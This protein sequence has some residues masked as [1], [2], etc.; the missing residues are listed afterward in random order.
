[1]RAA[2]GVV[3]TSTI[4]PVGALARVEHQ[5]REIEPP[6]REPE[7]FERL[8]HLADRR[9]HARRLP[10]FGPRTTR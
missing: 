2:A 3:T 5:V 6:G 10:G 7:A 9:S 4:Q 8:R 1:M